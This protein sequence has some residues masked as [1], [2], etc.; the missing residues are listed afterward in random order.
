MNKALKQLINIGVPVYNPL[1]ISI[2]NMS[3]ICSD[4]RYYTIEVERDI[5]RE[6]IDRVDK[7]VGTKPFNDKRDYIYT[8]DFYANDK[9][10]SVIDI[11]SKQRIINIFSNAYGEFDADTKEEAL[12]IIKS[13]RN[14][15]SD[16]YNLLVEKID[17]IEKLDFNDLIDEY[18]NNLNPEK[19]A[20][21]IAYLYLNEIK[22]ALVYNDMDKVQECLFFLT[23][24]INNKIDKNIEISINYDNVINYEKIKQEYETILMRYPFLRE[25][26]Y[27]RRL[28]ENKPLEDNKKVIDSLLN[29]EKIQVSESFVK[30][31]HNNQIDP[32][33]EKR[34]RREPTEEEKEEI[35]RYLEYKYYTFL[36]NSPIAQIEC[37]QA[38]SNY[39][40]FLY[41][42]G[43]M[44]ADRFKNVNTISQMKADSIYIFDDLTYEEMMKHNKTYLRRYSKIKPLNHSGDW[45][46]RVANIINMETPKE[47]HEK[48][49]QMVK[50]N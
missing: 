5:R 11:T 27:N 48:A 47:M 16:Y 19:T 35:E 18:T 14:N 43:M 4:H 2:F 34:T 38:F 32:S 10:T 9:S 23:A 33:L 46:S 24:F 13:K 44:P 37:P 41:E 30:P 49:K 6:A 7:L 12:S 20:L 50:T 36:K 26:N 25:L 3:L 22:E 8:L 39:I 15:Y 31:G 1:K 29:M 42:N 17:Q 28:F 45:E 40:A 21:Y